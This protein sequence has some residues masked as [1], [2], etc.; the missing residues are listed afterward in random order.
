MAAAAFRAGN[1]YG[2]L[3]GKMAYSLFTKVTYEF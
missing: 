3:S 1:A 2:A